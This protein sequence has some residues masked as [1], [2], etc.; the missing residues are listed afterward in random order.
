MPHNELTIHMMLTEHSIDAS[1]V[2]GV[3][4][5]PG[6]VV[7]EML[8]EQSQI[9]A[10]LLP[11]VVAGKYRPDI[12]IVI[13]TGPDVSLPVGATVCINPYWG[14]W[15]DGFEVP[16][17]ATTNQ[18]RIYGAT[19]PS[20]GEAERVPWDEA[21]PVHLVT[22]D[23]EVDMIATGKNL[24]I[25]RE[26]LVE[27][28]SGFDLPE[29]AKY[30]TGLAEVLSIGPDCDL[31]TRVGQVSVGDRIHHANEGVLDFAFADDEDMAI[32]GDFAVNLLIPAEVAA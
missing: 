1:A 17:Y 29:S 25:R 4:P 31:L 14:E 23:G 8:P 19:Y 18:V 5:T 6:R 21:I 20:R 2:R 3:C 26:P 27:K 30:W 12:G 15:I 13:A 28:Q 16:G 32:I 11:D 22:E 24:I 10:I 7:V 9:G